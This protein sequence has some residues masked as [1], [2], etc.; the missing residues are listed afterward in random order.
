MIYVYEIYIS[1]SVFAEM[2]A[3]LTNIKINIMFLLPIAIK[4]PHIKA[5]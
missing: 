2:I 4:K 3:I 5:E 1:M